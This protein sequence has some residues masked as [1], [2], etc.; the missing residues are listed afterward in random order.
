[1]AEKM[2]VVKLQ[3]NEIYP[4][5]QLFARAAN[6][7]DPLVIM[8][9]AAKTVLE[10]LMQRLGED[11]PKDL[12][13]F[14]SG[15]D[16]FFSYHISRG[17]VVDVV[18]LPDEGTWTLMISEPDLGSDPGNPEQIRQPVPGRVFETNI[19][20]CVN[21][22]KLECGFQTLIS[23][24][25]YAFEKAPVYRLTPV[26]MLAN[27]PDVGLSQV[28]ELSPY[29]K[30]VD[31]KTDLKSL[32]ELWKDEENRLPFVIFTSP[33]KNCPD[34]R[35][36][37]EFKPTLDL[38]IF[39]SALRN[40]SS[41][42]KV[43]EQEPDRDDGPAYDTAAFARSCFSFCRTYELS[44]ALTGELSDSV[45]RRL[46]PGD[47]VVLEPAEYGG[48]VNVIQ[49]SPLSSKQKQ[50]FEE[51]RNDM[52]CYFRGR[53]YRF[54]NVKF[55]STARGIMQSAAER[56]EK[57]AESSERGLKE[58]HAL[59]EAE[60]RSEIRDLEEE[61]EKLK[62]QISRL[63]QYGS[64]FENEKEEI[65]ASYERQ[66]AESRSVCDEKDAKIEFLLRKT[67]RPTE[68]SGIAEWV[69]KHFENRLILHPKAEELLLDRSA[70]SVSL[71]LIC[72][73]LDHLATDY[74][75][76]RYG[77]VSEDEMRTRCSDKYGRPFD[78]CPVGEMTVEYT[79]QQYKIK[80]FEGM[81]GKPVE[82]PLDWHLRVGND[83]ENLLRIYF[84]HDDKKKL[85]VVGSLPHHLRCVSIK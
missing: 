52:H 74:W 40:L 53:S 80:Y 78:I 39:S 16:P 84:L 12:T 83:S 30:K 85:I 22:G 48:G 34:P 65:R 3:K 75:D 36:V 37:P 43:M 68:H 51:L 35:S 73:A 56:L 21:G 41:V 59:R 38:S 7:G 10:W 79:P 29:S 18:S 70:R 60:L 62:A 28:T 26:K 27:D 54:G 76:N 24:P 2:K 4:T 15:E 72:D 19:G 31:T 69:K 32:L 5:F 23:D 55:L 71:N 50:I 42:P 63:K 81:R 77:D 11:A 47:T 61:I 9:K 20:F 25:G 14:F 46:N 44:A 66:L 49:Y 57:E 67:D 45:K 17:Y 64:E 33:K 8:K 58:A 1:M 6:K 82:S 13:E